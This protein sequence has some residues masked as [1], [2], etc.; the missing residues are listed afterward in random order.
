MKRTTALIGIA[1]LALPVGGARAEVYRYKCQGHT[2]QLDDVAGTIAWN[3]H[4][5][6][7]AHVI[8]GCRYNYPVDKAGST[9][10]LCT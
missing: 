5:F 9:A 6:S 7:N 1:L 2:V 8:E 4:V 3:G 10:E